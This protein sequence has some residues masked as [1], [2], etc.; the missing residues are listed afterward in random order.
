MS[1]L[2]VIVKCSCT[3]KAEYPWIS[4][5]AQYRGKHVELNRG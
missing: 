3:G 5:V 2:V 1:Q 4:L